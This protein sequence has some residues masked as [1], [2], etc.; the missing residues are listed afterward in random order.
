MGVTY[1]GDEKRAGRADMVA[2]ERFGF[3]GSS[4]V[5]ATPFQFRD[6]G[7]RSGVL[8]A[9]GRLSPGLSTL[10]IGRMDTG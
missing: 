2:F 9:E 10:R 3:C 8:S 4:M 7:R 6:R 5:M 1:G